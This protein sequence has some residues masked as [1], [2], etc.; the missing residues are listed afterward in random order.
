MCN[1]DFVFIYTDHNKVTQQ[2]WKTSDWNAVVLKQ[3][4]KNVIFVSLTFVSLYI[5]AV[6]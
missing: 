3:A 4:Y 2:P 5:P 6:G 1:G